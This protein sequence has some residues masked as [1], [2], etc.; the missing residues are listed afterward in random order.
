V[1]PRVQAPALSVIARWPPAEPLDILPLIALAPV[2][3]PFK[4]R[5]ATPVVPPEIVPPKTKMLE[6]L[7]LALLKV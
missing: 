4:F 2:L 7:A 1:P 6:E 3:A 5:V